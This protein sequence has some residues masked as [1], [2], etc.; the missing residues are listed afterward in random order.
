MVDQ[1]WLWSFRG[2]DGTD[3]VI[4]SFPDRTGVKGIRSMEMDKIRDLV[5]DPIGNT[6]NPI[7]NAA[8]LIFRIFATCSNIFDRCQQAEMLQFL[9]M[10]EF[11]IG[12]VVRLGLAADR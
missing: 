1:L 2:E 4:S 10:F 11:S 7:Q 3:I 6:R 5:L 8:D 9:Q 12:E